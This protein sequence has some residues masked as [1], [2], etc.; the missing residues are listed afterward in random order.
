MESGTAIYMA[1]KITF[2]GFLTGL[3]C[4]F[5]G[6]AIFSIIEQIR[7]TLPGSTFN[8]SLIP[9]FIVMG[10]IF[11]FLPAGIGGI[12]LELLLKNFQRKGKLSL[13]NATYTGALTAGFAGVIM[14]VIGLA[15]LTVVNSSTNSDGISRE[16]TIGIF[17]DQFFEESARSASEIL[18]VVMISC[19][20]GSLAGRF[21]ANQLLHSRNHSFPEKSA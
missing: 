2:S 17:F 19:A 7:Y 6:V 12:F 11:S 18:I 15:V 20:T 5:A 3:C 9:I 21:L 14:C 1:N 8:I 13:K 10:C 16:L 4:A